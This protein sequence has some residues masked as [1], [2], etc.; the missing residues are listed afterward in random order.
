MKIIATNY[1]N[2]PDLI[3]KS[4]EKNLICVISVIRG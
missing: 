2:Y 1:T 3:A 4:R